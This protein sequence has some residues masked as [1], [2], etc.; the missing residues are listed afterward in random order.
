MPG[1]EQRILLKADLL[2]YAFTQGRTGAVLGHAGSARARTFLWLVSVNTTHFS[3][4][5]RR[6]QSKQKTWQRAEIY[7][8]VPTSSGRIF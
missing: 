8:V 1:R 6:I 4:L 7:E 3:S 2:V 5:Y